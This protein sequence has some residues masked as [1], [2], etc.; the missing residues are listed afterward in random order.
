MRPA[1]RIVSSLVLLAALLV[2]VGCGP[3]M[4]HP[5]TAQ[6]RCLSCHG[7]GTSSK[8]V[9][10]PAGHAGRADDGCTKCHAAR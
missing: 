3:K 4:G 1:L 6:A 9:K 2:T 10:V 5:Y 8:A 7:A